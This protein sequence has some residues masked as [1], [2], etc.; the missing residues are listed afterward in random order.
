VVSIGQE[1]DVTVV[2]IDPA[3]RRIGLSMVES[4][5]AAKEASE[6]EQRRDT[7]AH[8]AKPGERTGLG[9]LGD[10]LAGSKPPKR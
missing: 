2:E 9:T 3:K 4:A 8:L 1:V 5:R 10:L 7:E 6:A